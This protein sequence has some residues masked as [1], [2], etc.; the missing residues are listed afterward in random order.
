MKTKLF[1][2]F[3]LLLCAVM[4]MAESQPSV[5]PAMIVHGTDGGRKVVQ[6]EDTDV[7]DLVVLQIGQSLSVNIPESELSGVKSITFAMIRVDETATATENT[8]PHI[9]HSIEKMIRDG[10]VIL[11]LQ[12]QNGA[13]VEYD[14]HGNKI[15]NK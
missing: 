12:M 4:V 10:Q 6:L 8:C 15:I 5:V 9:V 11:R 2:S 1:S 7:T 14:I 3:P 13:N